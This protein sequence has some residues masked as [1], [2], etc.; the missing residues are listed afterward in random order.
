MCRRSQVSRVCSKTRFYELLFII[1]KLFFFF[2]YPI[3]LCLIWAGRF[4]AAFWSKHWFWFEI[5]L[6]LFFVLFVYF[7]FSFFGDFEKSLLTTNNQLKS[8]WKHFG[9]SNRMKLSE[10]VVKLEHQLFFCFYF[11]ALKVKKKYFLE[12]RTAILS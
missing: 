4:Y 5:K 6:D 1:T 12:L 7:N 11:L 9:I 10:H 3:Y 2:I 8:F